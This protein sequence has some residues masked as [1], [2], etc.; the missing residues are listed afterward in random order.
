VA[1]SNSNGDSCQSYEYS[2]YGQ[3]A[4]SDPN[5]PNPY[6]FTGRRFDIETGLYYYRARYY[7]PHIGRF[8]QTDPIGYGDVINWYAY[9][10]NNPASQGNNAVSQK[11]KSGISLAI[12]VP[13]VIVPEYLH[14]PDPAGKSKTIPS[15]APTATRLV[16][17]ALTGHGGDLN[18]TDSEA[19]WDWAKDDDHWMG[20]LK[21]EMKYLI[22]QIWGHARNHHFDQETFTFNL[23]GWDFE[24]GLSGT[25]TTR[26][27]PYSYKLS[28]GAE[29][30]ENGYSKFNSMW[31]IHNN[32]V[33]LDYSF[34]FRQDGRSCTM[35]ADFTL[36]DW[37]N[38][39]SDIYPLDKRLEELFYYQPYDLNVSLGTHT[40]GWSMINGLTLDGEQWDW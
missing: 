20:E 23:D 38:L 15:G 35:T 37:M 39:E 12:I 27:I 7:N 2:A 25:Y 29:E 3:V 6:M 4:A 40:V 28:F 33:K 26:D 19:C 24:Y 10:G 5:H 34:S 21:R 11:D 14:P 36:I 17:H 16:W 13:R 30:A 18:Y 1:L 8:M 9:R 22:F 32:Q 31:W